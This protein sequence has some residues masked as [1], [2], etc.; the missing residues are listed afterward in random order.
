M[1]FSLDELRLLTLNVGYAVHDRDWNWNDVKSPFARLYYV[2]EGSAKVRLPSGIYD[3]TPGH[4]YLIPSFVLH[5]DICDS[6]F[7]HYYLHIYED[8]S[9]EKRLFEDL[10]FPFEQE[11][12]PNDLALFKRICELNPNM[13]LPQSNPDS[14]DNDSTLLRNI[15]TT[16]TMALWDRMES[17]GILYQLIAKF[18]KDADQKESTSD[19]RIQMVLSYIRRNIDSQMDISE[20]AVLACMSNDHFIRVFKKE[21]GETPMNYIT[22]KKIEKAELLLTTKSSSVKSI[23]YSLGYDDHSYFNRLFKS[24]VGKTPQQYREATK[25]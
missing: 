24:R 21:V 23:A 1:N 17:L 2:T 5:D 10:D 9:S 15:R 20:L 19:D 7:E 4:L 25:K 18:L 13:K 3:L 8:V 16:A 12:G 11:A 22:R 6:H 14:Y